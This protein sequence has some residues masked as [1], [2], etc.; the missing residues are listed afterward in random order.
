MDFIVESQDLILES[1]FLKN[2]KRW[3]FE[4]DLAFVYDCEFPVSKGH[5]LIC[6]IREAASPF[7][8]KPDEWGALFDLLE[9]VRIS[10]EKKYSPDGY[11]IGWNI[12]GTAGQSV[13]H[14]HMHVIPRY[15]GDHV[16]PRGG[17]CNETTP[18]Y[19]K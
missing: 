6:P 4:T 13:R 19:Y 5:F 11:N 7:E 18:E 14:C 8:L 2:S 12:G 9:K 10:L 15:K 1:P 3:L 17:I 16:N